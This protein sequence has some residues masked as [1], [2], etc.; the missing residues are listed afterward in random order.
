MAGGIE[1][2]RQH[3][4]RLPRKNRPASRHLW[5]PNEPDRPHHNVKPR[6]SLPEAK[7]TVL[8]VAILVVKLLK[9]DDAPVEKNRVSELPAQVRVRSGVRVWNAPPLQKLSLGKL[10]RTA[11]GVN[12]GTTAVGGLRIGRNAM[13]E[14]SPLPSL[15]LSAVGRSQSLNLS[16]D[17]LQPKTSWLL[18][19]TK[20]AARAAA[21]ANRPKVK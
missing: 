11:G 12:I 7:K 20:N 15:R 17:D 10:V 5:Q 21:V 6:N 4:R 9:R 16:N 14:R 2:E 8:Q 18:R 1:I 19:A 13:L 3:L